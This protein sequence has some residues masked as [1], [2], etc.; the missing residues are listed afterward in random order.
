MVVTKQALVF[1]YSSNFEEEYS[2]AQSNVTQ[3]LKD[4]K[5]NF[6]NTRVS[7]GSFDELDVIG[8]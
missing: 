2:D 1:F 8:S 5:V 3:D 4:C 7:K 6:Y